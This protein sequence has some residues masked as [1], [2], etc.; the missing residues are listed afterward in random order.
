MLTDQEIRDVAQEHIERFGS[1]LRLSR[2]VQLTD[3]AAVFYKVERP[4]TGSSTTLVS[5]FVV[6]REDGRIVSISPSMVMPGI[7]TKLWGWQAI[8]ADP[9]LMKAIVDPDF[10]D[11]RHVDVWSAIA[12]EVMKDV[13]AQ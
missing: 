13:A 12:R 3:P 7:I 5:P 4:E 2:P 10:S 1:E 11:A 6:L 8:R 9:A